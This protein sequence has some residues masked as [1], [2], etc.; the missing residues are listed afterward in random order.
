GGG[1]E[2]A[3]DCARAL[4]EALRGVGRDPLIADAVRAIDRAV[5]DSVH[6][7][8]LAGLVQGHLELAAGLQRRRDRDWQ[9][10]VSDLRRAA[11]QLR[12]AGTPLS[13]LARLH[14]A[15]CELR[16]GTPGA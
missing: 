9:A 1:A 12:R 13:G 10:A 2:H 11:R 5:R 8:R 6:P 15:I 7:E 4:G 3:L 14:L 16:G